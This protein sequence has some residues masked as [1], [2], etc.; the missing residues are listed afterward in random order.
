[1]I[2]THVTSDRVQ[3]GAPPPLDTGALNISSSGTPFPSDFCPKSLL[4]YCEIFADHKPSFE[5]VALT[6]TQTREW[7]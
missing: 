1:M 2:I 4:H 5:A 7:Y 3:G 6:L